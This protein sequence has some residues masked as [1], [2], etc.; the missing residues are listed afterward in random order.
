MSF[1]K[2]AETLITVDQRA[3]KAVDYISG[4]LIHNNFE[5]IHQVVLTYPEAHQLLKSVHA[6]ESFIKATL[7]AH[8]SIRDVKSADF[9]FSSAHSNE[10]PCKICSLLLHVITFIIAHVDS[11]H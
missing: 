4:M 8:V 1:Q 7:E 5:Q 11:Q 3:K 10:R 2:I 6:L 9:T